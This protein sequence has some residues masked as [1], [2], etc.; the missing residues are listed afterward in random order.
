[1]EGLVDRPARLR[2]PGQPAG[3]QADLHRYSSTRRAGRPRSNASA[4]GTLVHAAGG[5][6]AIETIQI[7]DRVLSQNTS[8]GVLSYQPVMAV[9]RTKTAATFRIAVDG[10]TIV[11]T[12]IHRFWKAGKGWTMARDLKAGDRLRMPGSVVE[13]RS[14]ENDKNQTVYNLD[15]AENGDFFVGRQG[16]LGARLQLREAGLGTVRSSAEC[17]RD[18]QSWREVGGTSRAEQCCRL[19]TVLCFENACPE[20]RLVQDAQS[21]CPFARTSTPFSNR[22]SRQRL[23]RWQCRRTRSSS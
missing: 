10:E 11:A 4:Q 14:V 12:G 19:G 7:G 6:R 16:V 15:V 8:T 1:M 9:H 22:N 13:V 23:G 3:N 5:P 21:R 18:R 17:G 2:F 20:Q